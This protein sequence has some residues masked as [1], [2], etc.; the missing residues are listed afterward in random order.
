M[1][2]DVW[3]EI[4]VHRLL[5]FKHIFPKFRSQTLE[6]AFPNIPF[7]ICF[8]SWSDV[9]FWFGLKSNRGW[10]HGRL[11]LLKVKC[12]NDPSTDASES[13]PTSLS[14]S[15]STST[16]ISSYS[17]CAGLGGLGF[18]E[19]AY[20]T[21]SKLTGSEAFCPIGGGSCSDILN[22]NYA[23]VYG[24]FFYPPTL[25]LQLTIMIDTVHFTFQVHMIYVTFLQKL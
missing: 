4:G 5:N 25:S 17:W 10:G 24:T 3:N 16:G 21:Y 22:S 6:V 15:S 11:V 13:G 1:N 20:L 8:F 12:L 14:S 23:V 19:T 2:F 9:S 7:L 18:L